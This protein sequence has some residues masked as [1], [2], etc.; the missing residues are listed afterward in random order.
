MTPFELFIVQYGNYPLK[1]MSSKKKAKTKQNKAKKKKKKTDI[2]KES[3]SSFDNYYFW[4]KLVSAKKG[5]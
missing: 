5:I 2:E 1:I 3:Y 4:N